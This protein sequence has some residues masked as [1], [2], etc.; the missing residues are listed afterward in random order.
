MVA[1]AISHYRAL[2]S[3]VWHRPVTKA[4]S[5]AEHA[6]SLDFDLAQIH[7]LYCGGL[8]QEES[9]QWLFRELAI[10]PYCVTYEDL[11]ADREST[12]RGVLKFLDIDADARGIGPP[13]LLR[14]AD[15]LS[16]EWEQRYNRL[17]VEAGF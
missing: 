7:Q 4:E 3:K 1:R 5:E 14:Q 8:F 11:V 13:K 17:S 15:A 9:W 12:L 2:H 10:A 16:E 6:P